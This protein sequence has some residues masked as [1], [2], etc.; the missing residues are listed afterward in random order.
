[1]HGAF[2]FAQVLL[3]RK[4]GDSRGDPLLLALL[5]M[6]CFPLK[7]CFKI[8]NGETEGAA[9]VRG[10]SRFLY[11][12]LLCSGFAILWCWGSKPGLWSYLASTLPTPECSPGPASLFAVSW[13]NL[14]VHCCASFALLRTNHKPSLLQERTFSNQRSRWFWI[15]TSSSCWVNRNLVW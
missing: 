14:T 13:N 15:Q 11:P 5:R 8:E 4:C 2:R 6:D 10:L 1:M 9:C 12:L 7:P 3:E